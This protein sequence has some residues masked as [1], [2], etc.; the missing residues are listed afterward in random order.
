[1]IREIYEKMTRAD[2]DHAKTMD[3]EG[4]KCEI[5]DDLQRLIDMIHF[6][7]AEDED[8]ALID[9]TMTTVSDIISEGTRLIEERHR[10]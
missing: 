6:G 3:F 7:S 1:M 4:M 9:A 10:R 5:D 2:K 8:I